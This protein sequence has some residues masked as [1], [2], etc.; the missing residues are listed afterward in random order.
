MYLRLYLGLLFN[1]SYKIQEEGPVQEINYVSD[2]EHG[3]LRIVS[4]EELDYHRF[5]ME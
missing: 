2:T 1:F 5:V 3:Y 4:E